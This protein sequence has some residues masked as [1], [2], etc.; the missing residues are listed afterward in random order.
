MSE[1]DAGPSNVR[2]LDVVASDGS[3]EQG[4]REDPGE[5]S[6]TT[7]KKSLGSVVHAECRSLQPTWQSWLPFFMLPGERIHAQSTLTR[8]RSF[9]LIV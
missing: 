8:I 6:K 7:L 1:S 9:S 4:L 2:R 3:F 5:E